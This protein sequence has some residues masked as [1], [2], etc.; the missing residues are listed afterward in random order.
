MM[1]DPTKLGISSCTK[2][3]NST[4]AAIIITDRFSWLQDIKALSFVDLIGE[5]RSVYP[6]TLKGDKVVDIRLT[7]YTENND[8]FQYTWTGEADGMDR[9][10]NPSGTTAQQ[11]QDHYTHWRGPF[12]KRT[13]Q[14]T[15]WH[16]LSR[17]YIEKQNLEI[18]A[19]VLLE[20]VSITRGG[21]NTLRGRIHSDQGAVISSRIRLIQATSTCSVKGMAAK[22]NKRW[23]EAICRK[24]RYELDLKAQSKELEAYV[25][26]QGFDLKRK[27]VETHERGNA[28]NKRTRTHQSL[29]EEV[30]LQANKT[31]GVG[32]ASTERGASGQSQEEALNP[33]SKSAALSRPYE[34]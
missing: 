12:G 9:G 14:I 15:I 25:R 5:I 23:K 33:R 19:W 17:E 13:M 18:G 6:T 22:E 27:K 3:D 10:V 11:S 16:Q 8:L 28:Y 34:D 26:D 2:Y 21:D 32:T 1:E 29:C 30:A 7:D 20:N 24:E 31:E 4:G